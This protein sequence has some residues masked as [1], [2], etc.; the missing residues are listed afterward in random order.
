MTV[1]KVVLSCPDHGKTTLIPQALLQSSYKCPRCSDD[2]R[3]SAKTR[4]F[5]AFVDDATTVHNGFYSYPE[6][7]F[8][9][10]RSKVRI[11]CPIHGEFIKSAQKHLGG[12]GCSPCTYNRGRAEGRYLGGYSPVFFDENPEL[13]SGPALIYYFRIG[14]IYK[15]GITA[16]KLSLRVK[17][18]RNK[19]AEPVEVLQT[20]ECTLEQ[21]YTLEQKILE[22][23]KESRVFRSWSTELFDKDVLGDSTLDQFIE[24]E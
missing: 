16:N 17:D 6:Q 22:R 7:E 1:G 14:D 5:E 20:F 23:F 8:V 2:R 11:E 13:A 9:N 4:P 24:K 18:M 12:R 3:V 19:S 15:V 10:R 21:A